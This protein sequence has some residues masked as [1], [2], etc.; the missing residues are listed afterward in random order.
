M[1]SKNTHSSYTPQR[2]V[3][4]SKIL[5][6]VCVWREGDVVLVGSI[7]VLVVLRVW[8]KR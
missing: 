8:G 6:Y 7:E 2:G 4:G 1:H 3:L 5:Y